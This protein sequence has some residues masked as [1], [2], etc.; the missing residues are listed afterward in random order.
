MKKIYTINGHFET[1][2]RS[3]VYTNAMNTN[4]N[5]KP[6][7]FCHCFTFDH[8]FFSDSFF[9]ALNVFFFGIDQCIFV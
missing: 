6:L 1:F 8:H 5:I 2:Y 4:T 9:F 7:I 3:K